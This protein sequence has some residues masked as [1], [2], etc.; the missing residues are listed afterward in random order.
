[1][2][3][4]LHDAVLNTDIKINDTFLFLTIKTIHSNKESNLI[5]ISK[6]AL[7]KLIPLLEKI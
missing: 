7:K 3:I 2:E 1:M 4:Q 5:H 6:D